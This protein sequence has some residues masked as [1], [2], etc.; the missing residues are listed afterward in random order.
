[1]MKILITLASVFFG[2]KAAKPFN[3]NFK[4]MAM[5][6]VD[7]IALKTRKPVILL[8]GGIV[9]IIFFCSG[10]L[11]AIMD[12]TR[13]FD[14]TGQVVASATLWTGIGIAAVFAIG[15]TWIFLVEWPGAK[16][17]AKRDLHKLDQKLHTKG[18]HQQHEH[19]VPG[20]EQAISLFV[21]DLLEERKAKRTRRESAS[22]AA[23][24]GADA[25][26]NPHPGYQEGSKEDP[27]GYA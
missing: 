21:L 20:I 3:F 9:S 18:H 17:Q 14:T 10:V 7:E 22:Q 19:E 26:T 5:E 12:A 11:I 24:T 15:Y 6:V 1:M 16:R 13:Q 23:R 27:R 4:D 25:M 2:A 8:L